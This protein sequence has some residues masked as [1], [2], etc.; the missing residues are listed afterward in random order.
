MIL[1]GTI[2]EKLKDGRIIKGY[3]TKESRDVQVQCY[4]SEFFGTESI[5][6]T[7]YSVEADALW[8]LRKLIR[9]KGGKIDE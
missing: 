4:D 8:C 7:D 5:D 2:S 3:Y 9:N 6:T 1:T